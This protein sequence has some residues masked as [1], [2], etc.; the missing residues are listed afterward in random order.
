M[1][2]IGQSA[3]EHSHGICRDCYQQM[4]GI[5]TLSEE[6]LDELPFGV[7]IL[8]ELGTV[9]A[10]NRAE[11]DLSG[12]CRKEVVGKN[13]FTEVAP[14]TSVQGFRGGFRE[15]CRSDEP[16]RTFRFTF[17][18]QTGAIPVQIVFLRMGQEVAVVVRKA[19]APSE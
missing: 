16:S 15:F 14:C 3:V 8:D 17:H 13:F 1:T 10:Y 7:I 12:R 19:L 4:R 18:F 5:P 2:L 11:G 9:L 6:E